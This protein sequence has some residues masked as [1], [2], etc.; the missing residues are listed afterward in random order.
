ML[1]SANIYYLPESK[2]TQMIDL[3]KDYIKYKVSRTEII[4]IE[5]QESVNIWRHIAIVKKDEPDFVTV[6]PIIGTT[7]NLLLNPGVFRK[8]AQRK[9]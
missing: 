1:K 4:Y 3:E 5:K 6:I 9:R 7:T 8:V 2:P